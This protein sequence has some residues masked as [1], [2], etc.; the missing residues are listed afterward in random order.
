MRT[1]RVPRATIKPS[2]RDEVFPSSSSTITP[3]QPPKQ[4]RI[5]TKWCRRWTE[6]TMQQLLDI[7]Q[8]QIHQ[9]IIALQSP[10]YCATSASIHR[11]HARA[12]SSSPR[13]NKKKTTP[14][15]M[16]ERVPSLPPLNLTDISLSIYLVKSSMFSFFGFSPPTWEPPP[17]P[18]RLEP[19]SLPPPPL[20]PP[21]A[22]RPR[23]LPRS[24]IRGHLLG[25]WCG[26]K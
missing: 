3:R 11:F 12:R 19:R 24:D 14:P 9:L 18:P 15:Q 5:R 4:E 16:S 26:V 22:P 17:L 20:P 2:E 1:R 21:P 10:G 6:R 23:K 25:G 7:I 13:K 8:H